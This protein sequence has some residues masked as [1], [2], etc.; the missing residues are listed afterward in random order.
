MNKY[1]LNSMYDMTQFV[2]C[3]ALLYTR[4]LLKYCTRIIVIIGNAS[5]FQEQIEQKA[6]SLNIW[7][8]IIAK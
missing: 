5:K 2:F 6:C 7:L 3:T 1:L 4:V 8:H